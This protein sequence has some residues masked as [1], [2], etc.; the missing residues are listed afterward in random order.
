MSLSTYNF[1]ANVPPTGVYTTSHAVDGQTQAETA[2]QTQTSSGTHV[3]SIL[4][5]QPMGHPAASVSAE[6]FRL[7]NQA[8]TAYDRNQLNHLFKQSLHFAPKAVSQVSGNQAATIATFLGSGAQG[9]EGYTRATVSLQ[10]PR[11]IE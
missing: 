3:D 7:G 11:L 1:S 4:V 8:R 6:S 9:S 10:G 2:R 5:F